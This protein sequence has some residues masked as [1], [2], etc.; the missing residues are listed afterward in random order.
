[1]CLLI[2]LQTCVGYR[3]FV[4]SKMAYP[5]MTG[6]AALHLLSGFSNR[7]LLFPAGVRTSLAVANEEYGDTFCIDSASAAGYRGSVRAKFD[8]AL[9]RLHFRP[10]S[11]NNIQPRPHLSFIHQLMTVRR[12]D[13]VVALLHLSLSIYPHDAFGAKPLGGSVGAC[14]FTVPLIHFPSYI[15]PEFV[16]FHIPTTAVAAAMAAADEHALDCV[17][18]ITQDHQAPSIFICTVFRQASPLQ[19]EQQFIPSSLLAAAAAHATGLSLEAPAEAVLH[20]LNQGTD[21][22]DDLSTVTLNLWLVDG[23]YSTSVQQLL[24]LIAASHYL[25][26]AVAVTQNALVN[27]SAVAAPQAS[28]LPP[29]CMHLVY[30]NK[31]FVGTVPTRYSQSILP[32]GRTNYSADVDSAGGHY[33]AT[34]LNRQQLW[35]NMIPELPENH[36]AQQQKLK[37]R[38]S[39]SHDMHSGGASGEVNASVKSIDLDLAAMPLEEHVVLDRCARADQLLKISFLLSYI[40]V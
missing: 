6:L 33:F 5:C 24:L 12:S 16:A 10:V 25:A 29:T 21:V 1:M 36:H 7:R 17:H 39:T 22:I 30:I 27:C 26:R 28:H 20:L 2:H 15:H 38:H 23:R 9:H 4:K 32:F 13:G 35:T 11:R 31:R 19:V 3:T 14:A 8:M 34:L 37:Y 40:F 18:D